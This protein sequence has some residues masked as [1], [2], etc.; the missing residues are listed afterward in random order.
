MACGKDPGIFRLMSS[1]RID[2]RHTPDAKACGDF[3]FLQPPKN[4]VGSE[5]NLLQEANCDKIQI[6]RF[7]LEQSHAVLQAWARTTPCSATGLGKS[8]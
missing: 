1:V 2:K 4:A 6:A 5:Y 3:A 7:G 8:G